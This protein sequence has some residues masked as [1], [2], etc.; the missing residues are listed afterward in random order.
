MG[1]GKIFIR[2]NALVIEAA[3]PEV[4]RANSGKHDL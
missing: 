4:L 1:G 2:L 3:S